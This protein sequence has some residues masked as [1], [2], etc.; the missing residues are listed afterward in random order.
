MVK[1]DRIW[2]DIMHILI[3]AVCKGGFI[4]M[5]FDQDDFPNFIIAK[6]FFKGMSAIRCL[7]RLLDLSVHKFGFIA[8]APQFRK[9]TN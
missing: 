9:K 5:I 2:A 3:R 4:C 7:P 6:L 1:K 8:F